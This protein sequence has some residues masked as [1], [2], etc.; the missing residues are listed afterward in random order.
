LDDTGAVF[1]VVAGDMRTAEG[2]SYGFS[3]K[4]VSTTKKL[5]STR[6]LKNGLFWLRMFA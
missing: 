5:V 4:L 3:K 1:F 6:R 2:G